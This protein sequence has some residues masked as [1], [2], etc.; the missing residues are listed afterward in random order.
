[1]NQNGSGSSLRAAPIAHSITRII[2]TT[3]SPRFLFPFRKYTFVD[4]AA[5]GAVLK[6]Q[7]TYPVAALLCQLRQRHQ[8]LANRTGNMAKQ[9]HIS[10]TIYKLDVILA[11]GGPL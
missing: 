10:S 11:L 6:T 7:S 4:F 9:A 8:S 5:C 3:V 2:H 1:M